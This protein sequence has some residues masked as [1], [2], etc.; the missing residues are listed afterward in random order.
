MQGESGVA[1][2]TGITVFNPVILSEEM[3]LVHMDMQTVIR[4][5]GLIPPGGSVLIALSGGPDSVALFH[6]LAALREP[7][8]LRLGAVHVNH[9][10]RKRAA[11][12]DEHFC[13]QLCETYRVDL[14]IV[15]EDIPA[16]AKRLR[17]G[18]EETAREFR[19]E[20]FEFLAVEDG[21]DHIAL[22][23]HQDDQVETILFRLLRGTGR[24]GLLGM[25]FCRGKIVRPLLGVG[26]ADLLDYLKQH[27]L[28]F[29]E[30]KTNESTRYTRNYLRNKLLPLIRD[31]INPQIDRALLSTAELLADEEL[32]LERQTAAMIRQVVLTTPGGKFHLAIEAFKRYDNVLRRRMLRRIAGAL[33]PLGQPPDRETIE[34]LD[35]FCL[36]SK[37]AM[38]LPD[39]LEAR[40]LDSGV[41]LMRRA[42]RPFEYELPLRGSIE[43]AD[44]ALTVK[45]RILPVR[46][47]KSA[48]TNWSVQIDAD[49]VAPP[50]VM[51]SI[52]P[53]DRLQ[54]LGLR[55]RKKVGNYLTDKKIPA[56]FRDEIPVICDQNG[57]IGLVGHQIDDRV[58][59]TG[60]TK[61]V[62]S[63]DVRTQ[64]GYRYPTG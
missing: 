15:T 64:K 24:T 6:V 60:T 9:R 32:Y 50:L 30:D 46:P 34:R 59:Q 53:G 22:G 47:T 38:S 52:R 21:Y 57:I 27:R 4:E 55:G 39:A 56:I 31:K 11:Q 62:L 3:Y 26:K 41:V 43:T 35:R 48:G 8:K 33:S 18:V 12:H 2:G 13:E 44:P 29:C 19:Y 17:K 20:F 42:K 14:T 51:R 45:I 58:K 28:S 23:H 25:P 37:K 54:P 7:M 36:E 49:K 16:L 1:C 10:I 63:I 61:R 5:S 40:R